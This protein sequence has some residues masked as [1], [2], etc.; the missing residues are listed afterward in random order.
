MCPATSP[1]GSIL[2]SLRS[3]CLTP[4]LPSVISR[5]SL[6]SNVATGSG[7]RAPAGKVST[8]FVRYAKD[9]LR[10]LS[11]LDWRRETW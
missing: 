10:C 7:S 5:V 9:S 1:G 2:N 8:M 4:E 3:C 11:V 6:G